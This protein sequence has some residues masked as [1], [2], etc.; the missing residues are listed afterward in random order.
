MK[1]RPNERL[2]LTNEMDWLKARTQVITA[3]EA[4][5]LFSINPY[6]SANKMFQRKTY[7]ELLDNVYIR[8]GKILE[9]AV[10][11][12]VN[13]VLKTT[14]KEEKGI[15]FYRLKDTPIGATP[16]ALGRTTILECKSTSLKKF[17]EDWDLYP[18]LYYLLQVHVQLLCT[19]RK[20]GYL[21][22]LPTDMTP[23]SF[24]SKI[25]L[26]I[27][28]ITADES[29]N[30]LLEDTCKLAYN[31]FVNGIEFKS[32]YTNNK[33]MKELLIKSAEFVEWDY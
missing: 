23:E 8:L 21:A 20:Y 10:I 28:K 16:D 33:R 18:P 4:S 30:I 5:T 22:A 14:F 3:T 7:P 9:P 29:I 2:V 25:K 11:N 27:Y 17:H 1:K 32:D 31:N 24:N 6:Q 26:K 13:M 15:I 12:A 19:G